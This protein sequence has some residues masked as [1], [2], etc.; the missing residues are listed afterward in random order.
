MANDS[1]FSTV[2]API[3][4]GELIDKITILEIKLAHARDAVQR[5]NV[6]HELTELQKLVTE[7]WAAILRTDK[8]ELAQVNRVIWDLEERV[9]A[10]HDQRA[11]DAEFIE[12]AI[13]IFER[14][15]Q[16][17]AIKRRINLRLGSNIVEEKIY[18][19]GGETAPC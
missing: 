3:S 8:P 12:C 10:K 17:A 15:D 16:R 1:V 6:D 5:R 4:V 18:H 2:L 14:N 11:H 19:R 7:D 9:R 13:A